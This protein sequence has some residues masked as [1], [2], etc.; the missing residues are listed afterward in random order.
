MTENIKISELFNSRKGE[1]EQQLTGLL[2][3]KEAN[4][5][6]QI[7]AD[8]LNG[9]FDSEGEFRQSLTQSED[10][11]L[12]AVL[13]L[14]NAQQ[15][16]SNNLIKRMS[17]I[18]SNVNV[19]QKSIKDEG[20]LNVKMNSTQSMVGSAGGALVGNLIWGGWGAVFG[21]MAGTAV[22]IYLAS[23]SN[24]ST[25]N[26]PIV[27]KMDVKYDQP[28]TSANAKD[29][30]AILSKVCGSVDD[31]IATFRAQ[32]NRVVSKYE[33][34][35]KPSIESL[36]RPVVENIQTLIGYSRTHADD[37]KFVKKICE[38]IEDMGEVLD[39]YN[40][41]VVDY[42]EE[43]DAWFEKAES[44][45]TDKKKMVYPA[46]VKGESVV[47]KGKVFIPVQ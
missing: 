30:T 9:L 10:Y 20:I 25:E 43:L 18:T 27:S 21:A 2:L 5:V 37:E 16:M 26:N 28:F 7:I 1:L 41:T 34:Q 35:D 36:Y 38:R 11:M 44:T 15:E 39:M 3:P 4:R 46:I 24:Q 22:A 17:E 14:L 31:M 29:L 42:S 32:I 40:L 47:L 45:N 8:Y 12:Q 13:S 6:Q 19:E 23:R 33:S